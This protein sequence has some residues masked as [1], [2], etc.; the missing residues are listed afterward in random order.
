[1]GPWGVQFTSKSRKGKRVRPAQSQGIKISQA[2]RSHL[3]SESI[4]EV[5]V[6]VKKGSKEY[7]Q[8]SEATALGVMGSGNHC[9]EHLSKNKAQKTV[10][11][12]LT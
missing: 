3:W 7:S 11:S 4:M 10:P 6:S 1:M 5:C 9:R 2:L 8:V 12:F